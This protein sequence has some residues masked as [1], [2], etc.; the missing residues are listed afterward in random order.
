M[1]DELIG[2]GVA[3]FAC[4]HPDAVSFVNVADAI[5]WPLARPQVAHVSARV[6][7]GLVKADPFDS[8]AH[9]GVKFHAQFDGAV[10]PLVDQPRAP[11]CSARSSSDRLLP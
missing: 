8:A 11:H 9:F 2:T 4:C 5:N 3:K 10:G 7:A 1:R 6:G